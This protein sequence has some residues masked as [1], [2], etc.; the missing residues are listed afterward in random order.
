[1]GMACTLIRRHVLERLAFRL[2]PDAVECCDWWLARDARAAGWS[3][4]ADLGLVCGH[5][6]PTPSPRVLWPDKDEPRL[7][8]VSRL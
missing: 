3:Q 7:W 1:V 4:R 6:S 5:I 2:Q 8:R